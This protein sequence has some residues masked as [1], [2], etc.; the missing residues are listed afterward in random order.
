MMDLWNSDIPTFEEYG[1]W[2][3]KQMYY[4]NRELLA[5]PDPFPNT[6]LVY[7]FRPWLLRGLG[8]R[9]VI[10]D[11]E[12]T[13]PSLERV[14]TES[15]TAGAVVNLYEI[16]GAN[17][18]QFSPTRVTWA[19]DFLAAV[20][21]LRQHPGL[22]QRVVL[23]GN[24]ERQPELVTAAHSRLVAVRDG[25]QLTASA[26]GWAMLVLPVQFS[27]CWQIEDSTSVEPPRLLRANIVQTAV[28]FKDKVDIRL[29]FDFEPW[30]ASCRFQDAHDLALFDF[31]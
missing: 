31:K 24:P 22:E 5:Q 13:D 7:L 6:L 2:V 21:A 10:V 29:R 12:L 23:L 9:F 1:Q 8:M 26:P 20:A 14:M 16:P 25:Y 15:G 19:P 17:H 28:L 11:G 18:G 4:F 27:H 3:S 30:R